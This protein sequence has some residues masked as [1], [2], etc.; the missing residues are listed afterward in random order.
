MK[1]I[2]V[3]TV[4]VAGL[5]FGGKKEVVGLSEPVKPIGNLNTQEKAEYTDKG[6]APKVLKEYVTP[7]GVC[8][9]K[10]NEAY[11]DVTLD[12]E[13]ASPYDAGIA[14]G[15]A[16]KEV[17]PDYC[18]VFEPYIWENIKAAFPDVKDDFKPA[19]ERM[20]KLFATVDDH[21]KQEIQGIAK[22]LGLK[23][24][25][26]VEDGVLSAEEFTIIQMIPDCLRQES[27]SGLSMWGKKTETGDMLAVRCLEWI[28]GSDMDMCKIHSVVHII[29]GEKSITNIGFLGLMDG[30]SGVSD[31]GLFAAILDV[32]TEQEYD[33]EGKEC[34]SF[35]VRHILETYDNAKEAGEYMVANSA[36]YTF[37]HIIM[38]T[39]GK[40][41]Y[42]AEDACGQ[43]QKSG[44]AYSILRDYKTPIMKNVEWDSPDSLCTVNSYLSEGNY[45]LMSG[46]EINAVRFAKYNRWV[47]D[48]DK[49]T[50]AK[51]KNMMTQEIVDNRVNGAS[52]ATTVH[53][54]SLTQMILLDYHEGS[55]QVAFTGVEGV[56]DKP[57]FYE[58]T[59]FIP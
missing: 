55:V 46:N 21:Y 29:N 6:T 15:K 5:L 16:I 56:K 58:V 38:L 52:V 10:V 47:K 4:L 35:A 37:S 17:F 54:D 14:Y 32:G 45:D 59:D 33:T 18:E 30:I 36:K 50:L 41:A 49:F 22:G 31:N 39:D 19:E 3:V 20:N 1:N 2:A 57:V 13:K 7:D 42:Y 11:Y 43:A 25:G 44:K 28:L 9:I 53:R 12:E 27:C 24:Q 51:I 8:K 48:T 26:L 23:S 40:E 34:Y